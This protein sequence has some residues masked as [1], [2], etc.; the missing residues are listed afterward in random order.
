MVVQAEKGWASPPSLVNPPAFE[1]R[2]GWGSL[3]YGCASGERLGQPPPIGIGILSLTTH[4]TG[5]TSYTEGDRLS[6]S[7]RRQLITSLG[8][9]TVISLGLFFTGWASANFEGWL[10]PQLPGF[11]LC[12]L[13]WGVPG[14]AHS[15][16]VRGAF[17]F[18]YL[19]ITLNLVFYGVLTQIVWNFVAR[20][21]RKR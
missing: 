9:G 7:M 15:S 4:H 14:F 20:S 17:L 8:V 1:N 13:I 16:Q 10:I 2:K 21:S 6:I 12:S 18:P 5:D 11:L 19:M 3:I